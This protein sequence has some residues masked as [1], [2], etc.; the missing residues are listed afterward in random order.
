MSGFIW[1]QVQE[2]VIWIWRKT[3]LHPIPPL[4]KLQTRW[5]TQWVHGWS[6]ICGNAANLNR[7]GAGRNDNSSQSIIMKVWNSGWW[8]LENRATRVVERSPPQRARS[9]LQEEDLEVLLRHRKRRTWVWYYVYVSLDSLLWTNASNS[10][11]ALIKMYV[12]YSVRSLCWK[13]L[14][15]VVIIFI[16]D[17]RY[18][19]FSFFGY[20]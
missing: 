8:I 9:L 3:L 19:F 10:V 1:S 6:W 12:K 2:K 4:Y 20:F 13:Y 14:Y 7:I 16:F 15:K 18:N 17:Q 5:A 11:Q